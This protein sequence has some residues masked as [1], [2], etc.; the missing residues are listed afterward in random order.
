MGQVWSALLSFDWKSWLGA[1]ASA[2]TILSF[3]AAYTLERRRR[4]VQRDYIR[5][6]LLAITPIESIDAAGGVLKPGVPAH[7]FDASLRPSRDEEREYDVTRDGQRFII[8]SVPPNIRSI[9]MTVVVNW[10]S[11]LERK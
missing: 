6:F 4:R 11:D 8:N 9:P 7:L 1:G 5:G 2:T 3:A 10:Q